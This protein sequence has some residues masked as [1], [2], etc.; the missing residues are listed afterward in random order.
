M[1]N[2][3]TLSLNFKSSR[4][5]MF[6]KIDVLEKFAIFAG[7]YLCWS[8]F[9]IKLQAWKSAILLKRDSNTDAFL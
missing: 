4:W 7:K 6:F 8:Y 9:L 5:Q 2:Q 3:K 1:I